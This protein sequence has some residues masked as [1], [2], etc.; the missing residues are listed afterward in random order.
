MVGVQWFRVDGKIMHMKVNEKSV[1]YGM[2]RITFGEAFGDG[3]RL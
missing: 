2:N 1:L 3:F